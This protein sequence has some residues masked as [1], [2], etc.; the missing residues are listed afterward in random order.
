[1]KLPG[2]PLHGPAAA[3]ANKSHP[4]WARALP[5]QR[6]REQLRA[7]GLRLVHPA[8]PSPAPP[9]CCVIRCQSMLLL[10]PITKLSPLVCW[11]KVLLRMRD[12][13]RGEN[14]FPVELPWDEVLP[15][16]EA[17]LVCVLYLSDCTDSPSLRLASCPVAGKRPWKCI[18][19]FCKTSGATWSQGSAL[20]IKRHHMS[21]PKMGRPATG[22]WT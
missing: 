4:T 14:S 2:P 21:S 18:C 17:A 1:M 15:S 8:T 5:H 20:R 11:M 6:E 3:P 19:C 16:P 10:Q 22:A 7:T 13:L 9:H 12:N